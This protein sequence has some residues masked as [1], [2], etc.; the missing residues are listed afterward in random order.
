MRMKH[1]VTT[2]QLAP[3]AQQVQVVERQGNARFER[4]LVFIATGEVRGKQDAAAIDAGHTGQQM[5]DL[6]AR[7]AL[8][9]AAG[10][11]QQ[12]QNLGIRIG[13]HGVEHAVDGAEPLERMHPGRYHGRVVDVGTVER[14]SD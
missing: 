6:A 5:L 10:G 11:R 14:R 9:T 1:A 2:K 13:L 12:P 7:H 4:P 3:V 8:E